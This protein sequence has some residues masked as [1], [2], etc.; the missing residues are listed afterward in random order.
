MNYWRPWGTARRLDDIESVL[1]KLELQGRRIM[2]SLAEIETRVS[3]LRDVG[4][5]TIAL[6]DGISQQLKDALADDDP[7]AMQ[8]VIDELDAQ[9]QALADAVTRNTPTAPTA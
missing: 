3:A 2:A 8:R 5:S 7:A 1:R 6:L 9:K 4:Q